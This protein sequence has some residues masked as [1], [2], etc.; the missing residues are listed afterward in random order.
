LPQFVNLQAT[1]P[2]GAVEGWGS[3]SSLFL[4]LLYPSLVLFTVVP[5]RAFTPDQRRE[6]RTIL[7]QNIAKI[8]IKDIDDHSI[9]DPIDRWRTIATTPGVWRF[10][11][12]R[13]AKLPAPDC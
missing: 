7:A 5:K 8:K 4:F 3:I 13:Q 6:F 11:N 1:M 2:T 12:E 10:M 9:R